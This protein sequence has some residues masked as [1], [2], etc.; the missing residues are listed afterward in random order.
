MKSVA[1]AF[2]GTGKYN[3][4]FASFYAKCVQHLFVDCERRFLVFT[5]RTYDRA[6]F[7]GCRFIRIAH[8]PWPMITVQRFRTILKAEADVAAADAFLFVDADMS[9][10]TTLRYDDVFQP[11]RR[12]VGVHHPFFYGTGQGTFDDDPRSRAYVASTE[13]RS[14]YWQGCLWGGVAP[15]AV[16]MIR[17]LR[18][19][20]DADLKAGIM[21]KWHDESHL[22][23]FF[24]DHK[25]FVT[26]LDPGFAYPEV[27]SPAGFERKIV[28]L[29]KDDKAFGNVGEGW[30]HLKKNKP[31]AAGPGGLWQALKA[32]LGRLTSPR[33]TVSPSQS[34][35]SR[36]PDL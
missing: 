8:E 36:R 10:E 13:D 7:P 19:M 6:A 22:N 4:F 12:Y 21:A 2:I 18:A 29:K 28:H 27:T 14:T 31:A 17:T 16:E 32:R 25:S 34:P 3:E 23:R 35:R 20:V 1:V 30:E 24:I 33:R 26:T 5:D 11:G 9:V 15:H